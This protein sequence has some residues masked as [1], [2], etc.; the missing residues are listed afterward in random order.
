MRFA[1]NRA[2]WGEIRT[3]R[4]IALASILTL[5][6]RSCR[7]LDLALAVSSG[8]TVKGPG[9]SK[10]AKLVPDHVFRHVHGHKLPPIMHSKGIADHLRNDGG[11]P[12]PRLDDSLITTP[13]QDLDLL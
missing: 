10:L 13:H 2:F 9:R 6:L 12:R 5:L 11:T 8:V 3:L 1:T 7:L 4:V